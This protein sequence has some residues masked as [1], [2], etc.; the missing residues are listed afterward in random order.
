[1]VYIGL[2]LSQYIL[3]TDE[4]STN[5]QQLA[6]D[7]PKKLNELEPG[8]EA[9]AFIMTIF[10]ALT[11]ITITWL[12]VS[13]YSK[14]IMWPNTCRQCFQLPRES[15][16]QPMRQTAT[17][18]ERRQ[19]NLHHEF[20]QWNRGL[21]RFIA[22]YDKCLIRQACQNWDYNDLVYERFVYQSFKTQLITQSNKLKELRL[23]QITDIT[24]RQ[25]LDLLSTVSDSS[26]ISGGSTKIPETKWTRYK[27][28]NIIF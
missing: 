1:M 17:E 16:K 7:R 21:W 12:F 27:D 28:N 13:T 14:Y 23:L 25:D 15:L 26:D 20:D 9:V 2:G 8:Y 4:R 22:Y 3:G 18:F 6:T 11:Y 5:Y 10:I 24:A 19:N